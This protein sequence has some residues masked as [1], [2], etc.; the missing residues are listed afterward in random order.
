MCFIA[1]C[2]LLKFS[3]Y[4]ITILTA[5]TFYP[6]SIDTFQLVLIPCHD[7]DNVVLS[8]VKFFNGLS[9]FFPLF[10]VCYIAAAVFGY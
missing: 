10:T 2:V 7:K 3:S 1:T 6:W 4:L 8:T 9:V 5:V